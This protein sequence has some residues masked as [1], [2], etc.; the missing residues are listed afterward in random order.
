MKQHFATLASFN[1][2]LAAAN[3]SS[4]D[5]STPL[6]GGGSLYS[7]RSRASIRPSDRSQG[8]MPT[9]FDVPEEAAG[10][11]GR[12]RGAVM[13]GSRSRC[14][15]PSALHHVARP[16]SDPTGHS[17]RRLSSATK[18]FSR[19]YIFFGVDPCPYQECHSPLLYARDKAAS[20]SV[21]VRMR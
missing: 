7:G 9:V 3:A 15:L 16:G 20:R 11:W 5:V 13:R 6:E 12:Q 10:A 1:A 2:C 18:A 17:G 19:L 8:F 21:R 14:S 4:G